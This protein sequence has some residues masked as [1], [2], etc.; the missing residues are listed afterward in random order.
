MTPSSSRTGVSGL[1]G[2]VHDARG[3]RLLG[4]LVGGCAQRSTA[5]GLACLLPLVGAGRLTGHD[6]LVKLLRGWR[7]GGSG[8]AVL[9]SR[10]RWH[11]PL[12]GARIGAHAAHAGLALP[13]GSRQVFV[14]NRPSL[15]GRLPPRC[16]R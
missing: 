8:G 11:R 7:W 10:G 14:L 15:T 4:V 5:D 13:R 3:W 1:A 2:A 6:L 9:G 16:P 12:R